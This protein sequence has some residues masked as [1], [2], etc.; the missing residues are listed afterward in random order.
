MSS[1]TRI[2]MSRPDNSSEILLKSASEGTEKSAAMVLTFVGDLPAAFTSASALKNNGGSGLRVKGAREC[3][4]LIR[5]E[6]LRRAT[7]YHNVKSIPGKLLGVGW[8]VW[9]TAK[10]E[11]ARPKGGPGKNEIL[12]SPMPSV[13]PVITAHLP[14]LLRLIPGKRR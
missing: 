6:L 5:L 1:Q 13:A 9:D 7:D 8:G 11:G 2:A 3:F 10:R 14:Y 4:P 12:P